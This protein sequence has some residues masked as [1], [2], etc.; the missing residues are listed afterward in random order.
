MGE[1]R[2]PEST[3]NGVFYSRKREQLPARQH[4]RPEAAAD[5]SRDPVPSWDP[6]H[7]PLAALLRAELC[8]LRPVPR[9]RS[10]SCS[11][12]LRD[13]HLRLLPAHRVEF[14]SVTLVV[15]PGTRR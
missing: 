9:L 14:E 4:R 10:R 5:A 7:R 2:G 3:A 11:F 8:G 12:V 15:L 13:L 1:R 6:A